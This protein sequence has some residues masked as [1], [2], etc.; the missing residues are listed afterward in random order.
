VVHDR[1]KT[2][3]PN[4]ITWQAQV[5]FVDFVVRVVE[6]A[7]E[8]AFLVDAVLD[9]DALLVEPTPVAAFLVFPLVVLDLTFLSVGFL[10]AYV[11]LTAESALVVEDF[12]AGFVDLAV[13]TCFLTALVDD[14][15]LAVDVF[16]DGALRPLA[17]FVRGDLPVTVFVLD[18]GL[19]AGFGTVLVV[20]VL[21]VFE[22]GL[23]SF[24][25]STTLGVLGGS[26]TRPDRPLGRKKIFFS[27]PRA[28]A[29]LS[30]VICA[31]PMTTLYFS[32]TNFLICGRETPWR[33]SSGLAAMHSLIISVQGGCDVTDLLDAFF[34][35]LEVDSFF[36]G[37]ITIEYTKF[38]G[39]YSAMKHRCCLKRQELN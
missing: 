21:E 23:F 31:F 13:G 17:G 16:E 2:G 28:I 35:A 20:A 4:A 19:V 24:A 8:L 6:P 11:F 18:P 26:L 7:L 9:L 37:A 12:P 36:A 25:S 33:A 10:P 39:I 22:A 34:G 32:S 15:A 30:C 27:A 38:A 14:T 5:R 29:L 1:S 3:F